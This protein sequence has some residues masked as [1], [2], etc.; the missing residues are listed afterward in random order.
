[1]PHYELHRGDGDDPELVSED[2]GIVDEQEAAV[3]VSDE[4]S[5]E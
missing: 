4:E 5:G 1:M 2:E 3:K